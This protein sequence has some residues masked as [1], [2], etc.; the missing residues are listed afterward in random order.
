MFSHQ[1]RIAESNDIKRRGRHLL[2]ELEL[3]ELAAGGVKLLGVSCCR[4]TSCASIDIEHTDDNAMVT[5][6]YEKCASWK[7]DVQIHDRRG[8]VHLLDLL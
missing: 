4:C 8:E 6:S 2:L 5:S 7:S 1:N 3:L